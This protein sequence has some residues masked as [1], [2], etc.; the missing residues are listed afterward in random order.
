[1][2]C[3]IEPRTIIGHLVHF[4]NRNLRETV[5][6][7]EAR[8]KINHEIMR[9]T[10]EWLRLDNERASWGDDY[11]SAAADSLNE[12]YIYYSLIKILK[13]VGSDKMVTT[14]KVNY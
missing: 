4:R 10:D 1:M 7:P 6:D 8:S 9:L 14:P 13:Y 12:I 5:T 2:Y 11:R 3:N